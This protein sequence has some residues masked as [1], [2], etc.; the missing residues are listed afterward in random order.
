MTSETII[1]VSLIVISIVAI[2]YLGWRSRQQG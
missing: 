1:V 2:A